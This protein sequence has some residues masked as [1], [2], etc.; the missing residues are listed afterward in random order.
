MEAPVVT[1]CGGATFDAARETRRKE[2]RRRGEHV[3]EGSGGGGGTVDSLDKAP[4][5]AV[6]A[7]G[8]HQRRRRKR[9]RERKNGVE[10]HILPRVCRNRCH[11]QWTASGKMAKDYASGWHLTEV[12]KIATMPSP[13][14]ILRFYGNRDV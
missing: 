10:Q 11:R 9:E 12:V 5:V 4:E 14:H 7:V 2:R 6:A 13:M 8:R 3:T 1:N